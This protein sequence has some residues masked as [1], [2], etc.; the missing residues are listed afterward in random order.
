MVVELPEVVV[1][2]KVKSEDVVEVDQRV[3]EAKRMWNLMK[4]KM[5]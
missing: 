2:V 3:A 1:G 4:R 5:S